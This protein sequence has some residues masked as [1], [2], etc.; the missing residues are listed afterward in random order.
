MIVWEIVF[1]M[2]HLGPNS[3]WQKVDCFWMFSDKIMFKLTL[4]ILEIFFNTTNY[5]M[6]AYARLNKIKVIV[7]KY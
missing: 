3:G 5:I 4:E 6:G 2:T 1:G 7:L